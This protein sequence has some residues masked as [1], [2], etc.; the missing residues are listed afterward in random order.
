PEAKTYPVFLKVTDFSG[1]ADTLTK[2]VSIRP[3]VR[4]FPYFEDFETG[5]NGWVSETETS[6]NSWEYGTPA[7]NSIKAAFSGTKAWVTGLAGGYLNNEKSMVSGPCFDF[8]SLKR[9]MLKFA[10]FSKSQ[11]G[12]DGAVLQTSVNGAP[13]TVLGAVGDV[14]NW[15]NDFSIEG[16][17]GGQA[18]GWTGNSENW[19]EARRKLDNL[20]AGNTA[21]IRFRVAFG[22]DANINDEGF[23]F[24]DVWIGE[25][26][27]NSIVENFA[28]TNSNASISANTALTNFLSSNP[29]DAV[30]LQYH[31]AFPTADMYNKAFPSGAAARSVLYGVS[32]VPTMV[33]NGTAFSG[34]VANLLLT[35]NIFDTEL[36]KDH[37][38]NVTIH[39]EVLDEKLKVLVELVKNTSESS[40]QDRLYIA[41]ADK[42]VDYKTETNTYTFSNVVRTMLPSTVGF[43]IGQAMLK[44]EIK[45]FEFTIPLN[46]FTHGGNLNIVGLVQN[47]NTRTICSAGTLNNLSVVTSVSEINKLG[48]CKLYPNPADQHIVIEFEQPTTEPMEIRIHD[49]S[50]RLQFSQSFEPGS[51]VF[52]IKTETLL[53]GM[54]LLSVKRKNETIYI[55]KLNI[56]R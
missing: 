6:T 8:S 14:V 54:Y 41:V 2:L 45:Q 1:C 47:A 9:P 40:I 30:L 28:N 7:G 22:S 31:T 36:L 16:N 12:F 35:P 44:G 42:T 34:T 48:K 43:E 32:E 24:D 5:T 4:N 52:A 39:A 11:S 33:L 51:A 25:R 3:F 23:A 18:Q 38:Y 13:W 10:Y 46:S 53:N 29:L 49:I 17:P 37:P 27:G 15:Y 20:L 26:T 19:T 56:M 21:N 55:E 50:G